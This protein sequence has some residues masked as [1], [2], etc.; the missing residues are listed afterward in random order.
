VPPDQIVKGYETDSG[1]V[2]LSDQERDEL[3]PERS[4]SIEVLE[5]VDL[6]D[7]DPIYFD[8][9]YFLAPDKGGDRGYALLSKALNA[10]GKVGL[11]QFVLRGKETL[12]A[13]RPYGGGLVLAGLRFESKLRSIEDLDLPGI[14]AVRGT[15]A[16]LDLAKQ[17]V[18]S[19][20]G[21]WVPEKYKD[22]YYE[23]LKDVVERKA[24][25]LAP[26]ERPVVTPK[27][28]LPDILAALEASIKANAKQKA[29]IAR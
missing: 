13:L 22:R 20:T 26:A 18:S 3:M 9:P 2:V 8:R 12:C 27:Q 19:M 4:K 5:F 28:V 21:D 6:D 11:A 7:I 23:D 1:V 29:S 17:L 15:K 10:T 14:T 16:E 25:G 24:K